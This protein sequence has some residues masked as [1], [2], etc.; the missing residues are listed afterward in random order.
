MGKRP[1]SEEEQHRRLMN[2]AGGPSEGD[3]SPM[4]LFR[5]KNNLT[6]KEVAEYLGIHKVFISRVETGDS[7]LS[8][9]RLAMLIDNDRGWDASMLVPRIAEKSPQPQTEGAAEDVTHQG[10][11][12][13]VWH[14]QTE[15][16]PS[17]DVARP[18]R[19][20]L[21]EPER[22]EYLIRTLEGGVAARFS[23]R[24]GIA[25]PKL[26]RVKSGEL[27]LYRLAGDILRTYPSV[28]REWLD[29]GVGYPGDLSIDLVRDRLMRVVEDRD[30]VIAAL[31]A[32]LDLQRRLIE[33]VLPPKKSDK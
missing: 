20:P 22:L 2:A 18:L 25:A 5:Y 26:S 9:K 13:A 10:A 15:P 11:C 6:Q 3:P 33:D 8:E 14:K 12:A 7:A 24:T 28:S 29:T 4:W 23:E 1:L 32:E 27:H 21:S 31:T 16:A 17:T 19:M 30:R